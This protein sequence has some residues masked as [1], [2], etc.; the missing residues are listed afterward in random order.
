MLTH[1][2]MT[3]QQACTV[4]A[5]VLLNEW[6]YRFGEPGHN[7]LDQGRSFESSL[8]QQLCAFYRVYKSRTTPYH[9]AGNGQC[10]R[11][12]QTLHNLLRPL[13]L[14]WKRD[15]TTCLPQ[16]L[17]C[18]NTAPLLTRPPENPFLWLFVD[19]LLGRALDHVP[20]TV[21]DWMIETGSVFLVCFVLECIIL[22][23]VL[24]ISL[25][26]LRLP[27]TLY[28]FGRDTTTMLVGLPAAVCQSWR[29]LA[30]LF[31]VT[32]CGMTHLDLDASIPYWTQYEIIWHSME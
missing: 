4:Q 10:E 17:Y 31:L 3:D 23:M 1:H 22:F 30:L 26:V 27:T 28:Y 12:N 8:M 9:L 7:H 18:Y 6:F 32:F 11:F 24:F 16:V 19:S 5:Q 20:G 13:P 21:P 15:W 25:S 2:I 14:T 29:T